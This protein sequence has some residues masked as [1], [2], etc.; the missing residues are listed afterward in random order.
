MAAVDNTSVPKGIQP[1]CDQSIRR[2]DEDKGEN[3]GLCE[4]KTHG[5]GR[6]D[7][8]GIGDKSWDR[9]SFVEF[10]KEKGKVRATDSWPAQYAVLPKKPIKVDNGQDF[11]NYMEKLKREN[12]ELKAENSRLRGGL[13]EC[14]RKLAGLAQSNRQAKYLWRSMILVNACWASA[15]FPGVSFE[16]QI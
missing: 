9:Y 4:E 2:G 5:R 10:I 3:F 7:Y 6:G 16:P 14:R 15:G 13:D 11:V 8:R 12:H 1:V